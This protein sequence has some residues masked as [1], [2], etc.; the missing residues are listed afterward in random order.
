LIGALFSLTPP[1]AP[2]TNWNLEVLREGLRFNNIVL[3]GRGALY[4]T[5]RQDGR[6]YGAAFKLT[7]PV[8]PAT[9][10][11]Y[12]TIAI[13]PYDLDTGMVLD[14]AS[15]A[16]YGTSASRGTGTVGGILFKLTPPV[17]PS[18]KW[19]NATLHDLFRYTD[20]VDPSRLLIGPNGVLYGTTNSGGAKDRGTVFQ[21]D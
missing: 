11:Q 3:D 1:V 5:T 15:G 9:T 7:P 18:L 8:A 12:A 21:F 13:F 17:A 20:G 19:T 14:S 6:L 16:L 2:A 10:W 4:G